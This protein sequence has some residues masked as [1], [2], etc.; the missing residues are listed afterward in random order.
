MRW[1]ERPRP[2]DV[3][4]ERSLDARIAPYQS[5]VLVGLYHPVHNNR[6]PIAE[7]GAAIAIDRWRPRQIQLE[8]RQLIYDR[9][10]SRT[11]GQRSWMAR[12]AALEPAGTAFCGTATGY[13][14]HGGA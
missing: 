6:S 3:E 12:R 1:L 11:D 2:Y 14:G 10:E 8:P 9:S 5:N 7:S 13:G 4:L